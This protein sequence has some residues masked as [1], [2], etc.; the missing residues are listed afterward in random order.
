MDSMQRAAVGFCTEE[1]QTARIG[2]METIAETVRRYTFAMEDFADVARA[3]TSYQL[4]A[5]AMNKGRDILQRAGLAASPPPVPEFDAVFRH[6][7]AGARE[8]LFSELRD[9]PTI[10]AINSLRIWK[11]LIQRSFGSGPRQG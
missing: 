1:Q 5:E 4:F 2:C 3:R 7:N 8:E 9:L 6:L 10:D 11:P